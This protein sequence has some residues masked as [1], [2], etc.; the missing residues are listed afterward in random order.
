MTAGTTTYTSPGISPRT[1]AYAAV[2]MLKY[3]NA[4][5]VLDKFGQTKPMPKNKGQVIKFRRPNTFSAASTPL[6]EGVTPSATQFSYTDVTANL[7][8]YGMV[9][10]ITDVI[11]DTHEDPVLN[12]AAQQCGDNIGRTIEFL[13]YGVVKAGTSVQYSNG[14]LRTSV[15]TPIALSKLRACVRGLMSQK[16][17][18]ITRIL[19][20]SPNYDVHPVEASYIAVC[21]TD[22]EADIRGLPGFIPVAGY[23]QRKTIHD[24]ELG[25]VENIRFVTSPDLA[26]FADGG[27]AKAGSGVTMLS[28]S[29][30][31][32]DVYPILIFGQDA[33]GTVPLKGFGAIDPTIIP[34]G[35][36]T[37]D[38]PLGQ[39][40][41]VGWKT[42]FCAVILN[43]AWMTRLEVAATA[44]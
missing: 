7:R 13:T 42:W 16:A 26:P 35:T 24:R 37:K 28:T 14:A 32:A 41:M 2:E 33:Y 9:V 36:K 18:P 10:E 40:G 23:G 3:A 31:L 25:T 5:V 34:V 20:G 6:V 4:V 17:M 39:R 44:L 11:A 22:L 8:Q 43:D 29:G 30:T 38:D 1:T 21:H 15:N 12:D 27:A 19:D